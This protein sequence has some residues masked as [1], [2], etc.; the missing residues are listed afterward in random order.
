MDE[1]YIQN[2]K[3]HFG[4]LSDLEGQR[5]DWLFLHSSIRFSYD[6]MY[7][8]F[9]DTL[10][11]IYMLKNQ[12]D[13]FENICFSDRLKDVLQHFAA[14]YDDFFLNEDY[15]FHSHYQYHDSILNDPKWKE[16]VDQASV[17]RLLLDI[18]IK[19]T[20]SNTKS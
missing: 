9:T 18:D 15:P 13:W 16:I 8:N 2:L 1:L 11:G 6:E 20:D 14:I 17:I 4:F 5:Q 10:G 3:S 7:Y 12:W 19:P